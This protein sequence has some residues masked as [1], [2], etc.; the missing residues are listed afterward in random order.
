MH[1]F[2]DVE[3]PLV[4]R[5]PLDAKWLRGR[6][7]RDQTKGFSLRE[8]YISWPHLK[9]CAWDQNKECWLV[10]TERVEPPATEVEESKGATE[11]EANN[12]T[13]L[14]YEQA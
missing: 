3:E 2:D 7:W 4:P 5:F 13:P 1:Y 8:V 12:R 11:I 14:L 6:T 10:N 9:M